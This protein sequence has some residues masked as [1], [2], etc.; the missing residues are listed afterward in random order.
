MWLVDGV[1]LNHLFQKNRKRCT[2][3]HKSTS[4]KENKKRKIACGVLRH[5][6]AGTFDQGTRWEE[7]VVCETRNEKHCTLRHKSPSQNKFGF[8]LNGQTLPTTDQHSVCGGHPRCRCYR[9]RGNCL[10]NNCCKC[11]P[12]V[13]EPWL[14]QDFERRK[15]ATPTVIM[16]TSGIW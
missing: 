8:P 11:Q 6:A 7:T 9:A 1:W 14:A 10:G 15:R 4:Q 5:H 13:G 3:R 16:S 2:Q 12:L